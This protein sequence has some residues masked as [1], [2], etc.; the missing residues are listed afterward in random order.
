MKRKHNQL[1]VVPRCGRHY[2]NPE[3]AA[4][5]EASVA[6]NLRQQEQSLVVT[7]R[8]RPCGAIPAGHKLM[9]VEGGRCFTLQAGIIYC[10]GVA[11]TAVAHDVVSMHRVG[12]GIVVVTT[13]GMIH[14]RIDGGR[15]IVVDKADAMPSIALTATE[16]SSFQQTIDAMKFDSAYTSW[17]AP[18]A[19]GDISLLTTMY[20][21]AWKEATAHHAAQGNFYTPVMACYGVRL[22]DDNYLCFSNPVTLGMDTADNAR[23]VTAQVTTE[24]SRYTGIEAATMTMNG[25]R[26]GIAVNGGVGEHWRSM[27]K[28]IDIFVTGLPMIADTSSLDYRCSTSQ[29]GSRVATLQYG[30]QAVPYNRIT[31]QLEA[32]P[33]TLVASTTDVDALSQGRFVAANVSYAMGSPVGAMGVGAEGGV[34]LTRQQVDTVMQ[35]EARLLPV[36]SVVRNGRLYLAT[37]DGTLACSA[38]GN[39][40]SITQSLRVTGARI[41]ALAPVLRPIYSGGFGRYAVYLF[42]DDGV[43]AVAQSATGVLGEARLV[44]RSVIAP[45]C[46]PVD[47]DRDIYYIDRNRWLCRLEGSAVYRLVPGIGV[48][49]MAW[50]DAHGEIACHDGSVLLSSTPQGY[51][52]RRTVDVSHLYNDVLRAIAVAPDGTMLDL[53]VEDDAE[54]CVEYL[55]HP[56]VIDRL[57]LNA[58]RGVS[59]CIA[60]DEAALSMAVTGE[61]GRSCHGFLLGRLRVSGR[62]SAPLNLPLL[63]PRCRTV[64]LHIE[65]S[66]V[67]GTV[68]LPATLST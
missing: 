4:A 8:P 57:M 29:G 63:S 22:W 67:A 10:D 40:M 38:H 28:A 33:W 68:I 49:S 6:V 17:R 24:S 21:N 27:V 56:I 43:Y 9:L 48:G 66:A 44:D 53:S 16:P 19:Q 25:Y 18:L 32:S 13:G 30:W 34:T 14:M 59:W 58:P 39:A 54:Q 36:A 37:T 5:G 61:R 50:D 35:A 46:G 11:V 23:A 20:R 51:Y 2:F 65:G 7:G 15:C 60:S 31:A 45:G 26:L 41:M 52:S 1:V 3:I 55:S 47:G 12:E 42:T 62:L 64:R